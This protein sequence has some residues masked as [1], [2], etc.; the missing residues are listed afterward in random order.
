MTP[1]QAA[2]LTGFDLGVAKNRAPDA[3]VR[4][5]RNFEGFFPNQNSIKNLR[6]SH[7]VWVDSSALHALRHVTPRIQLSRNFSLVN[8]FHFNIESETAG[9]TIPGCT[10][11][12]I[13][14]GGTF[15]P[16]S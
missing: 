4:G 14:W 9:E 13:A 6:S 15:F 1:D 2:T 8:S 11:S 3:G 10:I 5:W 12:T 16:R 7:S